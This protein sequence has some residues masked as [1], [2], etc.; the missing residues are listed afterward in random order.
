[1]AETGLKEI[2]THHETYITA[3]VVEGLKPKE[4]ADR[5]GINFPRLTTI[6]RSAVWKQ[7]EARI[8]KEH[9][10]Q[11]YRK[12]EAS[13]ES[14]IK[15]IVALI[16]HGKNE[17]TR[18]KAAQDLLDRCGMPKNTVITHDDSPSVKDLIPL[19]K[20]LAEEKAMLMAELGIK[21]I[22]ELDGTVIDVEVI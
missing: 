2:K 17:A 18:L 16:K 15:E 22:S 1:M 8:R 11:L 20:D 21:D 13:R 14:A 10:K 7:S 5:Y 4:V 19:A 6:M 9:T 3:M 12:F